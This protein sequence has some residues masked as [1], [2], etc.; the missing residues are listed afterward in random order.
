M[1]MVTVIIVNWNGGDLLRR[2]LSDLLRQTV[3]PARILVMDNDSSDGSAERVAGLP[4]VTM[5]M[6]GG[7]LGFAAGNNRA[8]AECDTEFVALLN[9]DAFPEPDWLEKLLAAARAYPDVAAF[10]S[11]QMAEEVDGVVDGLGD[12]YHLSGLVWRRG[13]GRSL[14]PSDLVPCEIFSPC[15]GA[16]LY[17][18]AAL[19]EVGGFD[20]DFFC[21][22]E[23]VDLGFRLR[24]AGYRSLYVPDAVV[25]HVGSAT[26]GGQHSDFSVYHGHRNLVWTYVKNMPGWLFWAFLPAHLLLNFVTLIHFTLS[27]Q[28]RVIWRAKRDALT[29]IHGMWRKRKQLQAMRRASLTDIWRVL[30]KRLIP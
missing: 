18:R 28:G 6:L 21:Y 30:D 9:P 10:G 4:G 25:H 7:N 8:F 20:E 23:D 16:A 29:G 11:R 27:G 3:P 2:C 5:R 15:A 14:E 17:R 1:P 26:T 13:H 22:V 24:L 12:V 19:A